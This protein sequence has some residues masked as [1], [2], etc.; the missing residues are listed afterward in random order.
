LPPHPPRRPLE[1]DTLLDGADYSI[2]P[3]QLI[4]GGWLGC[5]AKSNV[6]KIS[7]FFMGAVLLQNAKVQNQWN[8]L[9]TYKN[10]MPVA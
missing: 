9:K 2:F 6:A 4:Y 8:V 1:T 7:K 5:V 10:V 3:N